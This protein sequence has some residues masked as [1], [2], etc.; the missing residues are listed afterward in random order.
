M[1]Y[2][3]FREILKNV[4]KKLVST[5]LIVAMLLCCIHASSRVHSNT[6][7]VSGF[8]MMA[9][10]GAI[11]WPAFAFTAIPIVVMAIMPGSKGVKVA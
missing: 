4:C 6:K 1:T 11:S 2:F 7:A 3:S 8:N 10:T 9:C 5:S